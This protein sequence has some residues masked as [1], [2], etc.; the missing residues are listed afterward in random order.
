MSRW[1]SKLNGFLYILDLSSI[2][3]KETV[4]AIAMAHAEVFKTNG[5][6]KYKKKQIWECNSL[7]QQ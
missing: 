4:V 6:W 5:I 2:T 7:G 1:Q 3:L